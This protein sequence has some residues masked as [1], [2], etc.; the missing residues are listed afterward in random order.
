M[1]Q[2]NLTVAAYQDTQPEGFSGFM[3][4]MYLQMISSTD[5]PYTAKLFIYFLMTEKGFTSAFQTKAADIGTYSA[6]STIASLEGDK[7]LSFWKDC[8][9][10][11][12]P[13][14]LQEAYA[15][16]I[17]DFITYCTNK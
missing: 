16:G 2:E 12:D 9:V 17:L 15:S 3:Y 8:L 1:T 11:E 4:P 10:C 14:Y 6:N 13:Q 5:R 7:D